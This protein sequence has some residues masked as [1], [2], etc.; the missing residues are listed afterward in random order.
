MCHFVFNKKKYKN[1]KQ[2]LEVN[3]LCNGKRNLITSVVR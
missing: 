3:L 1:K 2:H